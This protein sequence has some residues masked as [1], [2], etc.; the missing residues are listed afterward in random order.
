MLL[1]RLEAYATIRGGHAVHDYL[2]GRSLALPVTGD[3]ETAHA[4]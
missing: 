4:L 3:M 1:Y 2:L